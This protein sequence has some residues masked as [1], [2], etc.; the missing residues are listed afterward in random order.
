MHDQ[1]L[2]RCLQQ[3][4]HHE[5]NIRRLFEFSPFFAELMRD[6]E[7]AE[8]RAVFEVA[9]SDY[10]PNTSSIWQPSIDCEGMDAGMAELRRIKR[11]GMRHILWWEMGLQSD[12]LASAFSLSCLASNLLEAGLQM[13][14]NLIGLRHGQIDGGKFC[15]IGL[16]KLGGSE[17]NLG[18]DIDLL[19]LWQ[20]RARQSDGTRSLEA[21][22]YFQRLSRLLLKLM[23]EYTK[24]GRAWI[25]DMRLR[26]GGDGTP[27][28][29][30][31]DATL[32]HFQNYGQTW[33][34]AML[35]KA[36]PVA[37]NLSLGHKF[38]GG[39]VPFIFR[40]YLDYT[41][42][43]ALGDMKRR[44]D[45]EA[46]KKGIEAGF[47]VKRSR[48]GI[49]EIEFLIQ[50]LQ[51]L[52]GG[53]YPELRAQPSMSALKKLLLTE[54]IDVRQADELQHAYIFWRK[55]EHALQAR[56][57]EQ[58]HLLFEGYEQYLSQALSLPGVQTLMQEQ[59]TVVQ[60][61]FRSRF[62]EHK[63]GS[64]VELP[65]LEASESEWD[66]RLLTED[67]DNK[68]RLK[69]A[70]Q[71]IR[72]DAKRDLLPERGRNQISQIVDQAML[73]WQ[74]DAN[75]VQALEALTKLFRQISGRTTWI[76][77]LSSHKAVL[78]WLLDVLAASAYIRDHLIR[79]PGW[80]EWPIENEHGKDRIEHIE[81]RFKE[82][83][84]SELAD[85][86]CLADMA[87]LVDQARITTAMAIATDKADPL[88]VGSWLAATADQ[89]VM[90]ALQLSLRQLKLPPDFPLVC[91]ALGK[92]GSCEMGLVSDLDLVFILVHED[93]A[94]I[95][96]ENRSKREWS[97]R[98][99]RRIIQHLTTPA[100]Y[101]AAYDFDARLRPS[102]R[103]GVLVTT[104]EAF[105][106]Y[107][108]NE[109][110]TWEHQALCRSRTVAGPKT[111]QSMV[112]GLVDSIIS[113]P[114]KVDKLTHDVVEM[115]ARMLEHL[116][117][118]DQLTINLKHDAGGLVDLEFLA[119]YARL[120]FGGSH[121]GT[122]QILRDLP[123]AT[124]EPWQ[125]RS[126]QLAQTYLDYRQ[127]ENVLRV[128]L[129]QSIGRLS[130]SESANEWETMR[131]HAPI[132]SPIVLHERMRWAHEQFLLLLNEDEE[133]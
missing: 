119:Q 40:R 36:R 28:C 132:K 46:G 81:K 45:V 88:S 113:K 108:H 39:L 72:N 25:T 118:K 98:L 29:L 1:T 14:K 114:R 43:H 71:E 117:S 59:A 77:L 70:L 42:V 64:G 51:L 78:A 38:I 32:Q 104:I 21:G 84:S 24:D 27:L 91:L 57:G 11:K 85:E 16:G 128:Q 110:Q 79:N 44:I 102:G 8:C 48:G 124:P 3:S 49:R 30:S 52:F 112:R 73:S 131:R 121:T 54:M 10:L 107:Q 76:D 126:Q 103:A 31:L 68:R 63:A 35:I 41:T 125:E 67:N 83:F 18:S 80:L 7:E 37:G 50:S 106:D 100:P 97:Q 111:A 4:S 75:R 82:I 65:W 62:P 92:H 12:V 90:I 87:R 47:D 33:E 105:S 13:A 15:I 9:A 58:T 99:G 19:F 2:Q 133:I 116:Q 20:A 56:C 96:P 23:S 120:R 122:V 66:Q 129:W 22:E 60:A 109:A 93:P 6:T 115:R 61:H 55:I 94:S 123:E 101:G 86:D 26:P 69:L 5:T 53:R 127:M 34:R 130:A 17:L 74:G 95:G 89:A